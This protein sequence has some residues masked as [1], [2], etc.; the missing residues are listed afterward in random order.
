M[1]PGLLVS[2]SPLWRPTGPELPNRVHSHLSYHFRLLRGCR[3]RRTSSLLWTRRRHRL[4]PAP[5]RSSL[6]SPCFRK[7]TLHHLHLAPR[8]SLTSPSRPCFRWGA[9]FFFGR[10]GRRRRWKKHR[11][12]LMPKPMMPSLAVLT[13]L[14]VTS[15]PSWKPIGPGPPY[16]MQRHLSCHL[17]TPSRVH[18]HLRVQ[19]STPKRG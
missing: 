5:P 1:M 8:S 12:N 2:S 19:L 16:R 9:N 18:R 3:R 13:R 11:S 15:L 6:T 10:G 4:H 7:R 14:A 17:R